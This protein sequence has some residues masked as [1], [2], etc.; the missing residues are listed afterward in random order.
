MTDATSARTIRTTRS[1]SS[2]KAGSLLRCVHVYRVSEVPTSEGPRFGVPPLG[3][4]AIG[5]GRIWR[6]RMPRRLKAGLQTSQGTQPITTLCI[7]FILRSIGVGG[8]SLGMIGGPMD[9]VG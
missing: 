1:S 7:A 6:F 8:D 3:G 5:S 9:V 4:Q 2:V